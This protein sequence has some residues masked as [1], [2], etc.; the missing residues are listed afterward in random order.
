M[1]IHVGFTSQ[2]GAF[3]LLYKLIVSSKDK[4]PISFPGIA[5]CEFAQLLE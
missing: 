1:Q 5:A 2:G 4:F 3:W